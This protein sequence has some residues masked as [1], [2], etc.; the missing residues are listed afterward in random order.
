[1]PKE[2]KRKRARVNVGRDAQGNIIYKWASGY[3]QRELNADIRRIEAEYADAP[4]FAPAPQEP[5][6]PVVPPSPMFREFA[7]NWYAL[8]KEPNI[9]EKTRDMYHNAFKNHILPE[10]GDTPI[11]EIKGDELQRFIIQY[12]EVSQSL[13]DKIMLTLRQVFRYALEED[14]I[15]KNPT[16]KMRPPKGV[17]RERKPLTMAEVKELVECA[18]DSEDGLLPVFL[19]LT[20]LRRGEALGLRWEDIRNGYIHVMQA[21][22]FDE[23]TT[24]IGPTKTK[25]ARRAIPVSDY[26]T[27]ILG[28]PGRGY[29]FGGDTV[30]TKSKYRRT[31]DR[32]RATIPI[33]QGVSAHVLRHT[34]TMLL[35]RAGVDSATA[36]YLLGH[37]NYSTTANYYTHIGEDDLGEAMAKMG[38]LLP[39]LLP[40]A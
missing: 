28:K 3:S 21:A 4:L 14:I 37:E 25:A 5:P 26:L 35:R 9:G 6:K 20:G 24:Y 29:V 27:D 40:H 38:S 1:M 15:I 19:V 11:A 39:K 8:Y 33:L 12:D 34:Y 22:K 30:W 13:I 7:M 17:V 31:W 10:F 18:S 2:K 16:L 23:N 32:L 36:Q